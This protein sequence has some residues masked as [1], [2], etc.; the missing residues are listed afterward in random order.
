MSTHTSLAQ[1]CKQMLDSLLGGPR[2]TLCLNI[3]EPGFAAD[4]VA[5]EHLRG[6]GREVEV[7]DA[8]N[9]TELTALLD[10]IAGKTVVVTYDDL[11]HHPKCIEV[12][13]AHVQKPEPGGKLVV[14]SRKWNSD[15]TDTE[16]ELRKHCLFYQ[17]N[18]AKPP[19]K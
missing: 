1:T 7:H 2:N 8:P 15:N 3:A 5:L 14:V 13:L 12:L 9:A 11:D 17:Q 4:Q 16:R 19:K 10:G 6:A 18:L